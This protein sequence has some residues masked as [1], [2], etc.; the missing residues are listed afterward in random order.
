MSICSKAIVMKL[1]PHEYRNLVQLATMQRKSL[2]D[3]VREHLCLP[4]ASAAQLQLSRV[5]PERHLRVVG[6]GR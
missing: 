6:G 3:T 1:T 2:S 5:S 4:P